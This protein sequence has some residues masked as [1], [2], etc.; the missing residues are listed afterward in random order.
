MTQIWTEERL[1]ADWLLLPLEQDLL[2]RRRGATRLGFAL[3]LKFFQLEGR[4][5]AS[6]SEIP[7]QA[8]DFVARQMGEMPEQ[9]EDYPWDG[10]MAKYHRAEIRQWLE[11]REA[12]PQ[13]IRDLERWLVEEVLDQEHRLERLRETSLERFRKLR[14][15]PPTPNRLNR[16]IKSA[17]R[18]HETRFCEDVFDR[19]DRKALA[20]LE[21]LLKPQPTEEEGTEWTDW[22]ALKADPGKAGLEGVREA[23]SS[24]KQVHELGL[25]VDLLKATPPKLLER[26]AKRAAVEEPFELR[27]HPAPI[28]AAL[29]VCYLRRRSEDLT[30][31]LVDLLLETIHKMGKRA[32]HKVEEELAGQLHKVPG[33]LSVLIRMA[34]ASLAAPK[35]V[36]DEVIYPVASEKL[37]RSLLQEI[38]NTGPAYNTT[39]R[40][41]IQRSYKSYYRRMLPELLGTLEFH[42]T[43][44]RHKPVMQA[45]E[46][47]KTHL[48]HKGPDYLASVEVPLEGV[49]RPI[50]M[51][52]VVEEGPEGK[53]RIN[54]FAFEICVLKA[55]REQVRCREIWVAGSRRFRD[56]EEDLPQDF[57]ARRETYYAELGIPLNAKAFTM[58]LREEMTRVL[59]L[60]DEGLPSNSKVK[61]L[62]KK[63]GWIALSPFEPQPEPENLSFLKGEISRRWPMTSLLDVLKDAD[64]RTRFSALLRSGTEREHLDRK[65]LQRRLLLCL[66]GL[67]TNTGLKSM[68]SGPE[69][70]Y[71]D[72]IYVRRRFLS[73]D[74]LRQAIAQVVNA[75]LE[76]RLPQVWGEATTACASDSKQFGSWDQ[77]LLT[78]W[79]MRYGGRGVMVYWHV[80]RK[81][82]CIYSQLKK[83][84]SSEAS[85]MIEGVLRH[86]T[87]MEVERQYVDSHGQSEV[88]FAFCHL[89]GFELMPRL[90]GIHRQKLYRPVTGQPEAFPNLQ[91]VLTRPINWE[92]IEQQLDVMVKYTIALR[93]G[94]ADAESILRRFTRN[95]LQ[96]PAYKALGELGK[97]IKTIFLCRYLSSEELRR[98]VNEGLNVVESWN[99]ANGFIFYGKGGELATNRRENQELGLLSLHLLQS[100]LVYINTLMIQQVLAEPTWA[101]RMTTRDL[102]ALSPLLTQHINPYG[103][104]ELDMNARLPLVFPV[105]TSA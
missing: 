73:V 77:N 13:D 64:L 8:V 2:H 33:K 99:A 44:I 67:G 26:Y 65:T 28:R 51:P 9:W 40:K 30:D 63:E 24:L 38:R 61:I 4:F 70:D 45:L 12:T 57:E 6:P 96:H 101:G 50:W 39:V 18:A 49:V 19:L 23:A 71:K 60:L 66:H 25:P 15:E 84:S 72:L 56:P 62:P 46:V 74:Q 98:E 14:I 37:L 82:T 36:V 76:V 97:A 83:V 95:N 52:L 91:P 35:G 29:M 34:E 53:P 79:H 102:S 86:C 85:S 31:N 103:R 94:T 21:G 93:Q 88:A 32:E 55:L 78:E 54:R 75:T 87:E 89:L 5:A 105:E 10:R 59:K 42:C 3:Q 11:F 7:P 90:K 47:M 41:V 100:S 27:R 22:Q 68:A 20:R 81:S 16:H 43:N 104:F 69:D 48:G 58:G 80:E 1:V 17:L 92:L